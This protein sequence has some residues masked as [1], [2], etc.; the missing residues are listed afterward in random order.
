MQ[1]LN[2]MTKENAL[3]LVN[4]VCDGVALT[5]PNRVIL[6]AAIAYLANLPEPEKPA[7]APPK[8]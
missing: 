7:E 3:M 1:N 2:E 8:T 6:D 4:Q 5:R